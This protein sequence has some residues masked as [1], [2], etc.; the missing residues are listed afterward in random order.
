MFRVQSFRQPDI[1]AASSRPAI[2]SAILEV[3]R[4]VWQLADFGARG[5]IL[6]PPAIGNARPEQEQ[7]HPDT[8]HGLPERG[9]SELITNSLGSKCRRGSPYEFVV[10][11]CCSAE[12]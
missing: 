6:G 12:N 11:S 3:P 7:H 9:E 2:P 10:H 8:L 4:L 5:N 1:R